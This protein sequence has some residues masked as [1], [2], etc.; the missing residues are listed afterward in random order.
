[1]I[2]L[3]HVQP[4]KS[5]SEVASKKLVVQIKHLQFCRFW[6]I[7]VS[8]WGKLSSVNRPLSF[9]ALAMAWPKIRQEPKGPK[10]GLVIATATSS[11]FHL[12]CFEVSII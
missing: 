7:Q 5:T 2:I 10:A 1:M 11:D 6:F 3:Y 12:M 9:A 8:F 4:Q